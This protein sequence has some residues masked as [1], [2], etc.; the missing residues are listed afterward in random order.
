MLFLLLE[1]LFWV[2]IVQIWRYRGKAKE[3][4]VLH[5]ENPEIA[6]M[7]EDRKGNWTIIM[8]LAFALSNLFAFMMIW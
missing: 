2:G 3:A 8:V 5:P 7:Y 1:I 4:K 6:K